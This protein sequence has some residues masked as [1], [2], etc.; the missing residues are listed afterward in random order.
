MSVQTQTWQLYYGVHD[1]Y[2]SYRP[3]YRLDSEIAALEG[4]SRLAAEHGIVDIGCGTGI[5]TRE[6]TELF[7]RAKFVLG[8]DP[9]DDMRNKAVERSGASSAS[10]RV[11]PQYIVGFAEAIPVGDN[12][13]GLVTAATAAHWFDRSAFYTEV[14]RILI[15]GGLL[16]I[17]QH[18]PRPDASQFM[19]DFESFQER[20]VPMYRRGLYSDSTGGYSEA[21]FVDELERDAGFTGVQRIAKDW[22][23]LVPARAFRGYCLSMS[24]MKKA[25]ELH[26]EKAVLENLDRLIAKHAD[27][28]GDV[29]VRYRTEM[30][31]ATRC[32]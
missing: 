31:V 5:F 26:T 23:R 30:T 11:V 9:N 21:N 14:K 25:Y 29:E 19:S 1:D 7:P 2:D 3:G 22:N 24:H 20:H 6:L 4:V 32:R 15:D 8:V 28:R 18:K 17:L 10:P 12:S 13:C 16:L 27:E